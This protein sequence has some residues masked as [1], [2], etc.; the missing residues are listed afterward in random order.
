[1]ELQPVEDSSGVYT[2]KGTDEGDN[3]T[4][5][6]VRRESGADSEGMS[7]DRLTGKLG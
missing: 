5:Q 6:G 2:R 4:Q 1:M 3:S 7:Q